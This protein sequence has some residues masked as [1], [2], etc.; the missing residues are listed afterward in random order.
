MTDQDGWF[1]VQQA[2]FGYGGVLASLRTARWV[3]HIWRTVGAE[4]KPHQLAMAVANGL[5]I[6]PTLVTNELDQARAFIEKHKA[7]VYKPLHGTELQ[8][9]S[10]TPEVIWVRPVNLDDLD[11]RVGLTAHMFQAQLVD[12]TADVRT[13]VIGQRIFSVRISSPHIDWRENYADVTYSVV[14]TP[15]RIARACHNYL[16]GFGLLFGAFDFGIGRDG[17]W[18]FYEC[19]TAGQWHWLEAQT[20]LPMTKA[21]ADLLGELP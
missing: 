3:N 1:A 4:Y 17:E 21:L 11:A 18:I 12:K 16:H 6:P 2:R 13:T 20:G 5:A 8:N 10:G 19:N 15:P 9:E 14:R 7:V